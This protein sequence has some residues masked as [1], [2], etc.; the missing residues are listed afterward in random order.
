MLQNTHLSCQNLVDIQ[1][2]FKIKNG[3]SK[4]SLGD[5]GAVV[6]DPS[7]LEVKGTKASRNK[8]HPKWGI[9]PLDDEQVAY[10]AKD[11]YV[12]YEVYMR[13]VQMRECLLEAQE[14]CNKKKK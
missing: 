6:I 8:L 13:I 9:F 7:F 12:D 1:E 14:L 5:L 10:A 3:K 4:D 2:E 11:A